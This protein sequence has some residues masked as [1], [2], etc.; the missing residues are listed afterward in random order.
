MSSFALYRL[1]RGVF[2]HFLKFLDRHFCIFSSFFNR[3]TAFSHLLDQH[4]HLTNPNAFFSAFGLD[5]L[6]KIAHNKY[7]SFQFFAHCNAKLF[8]ENFLF[9]RSCF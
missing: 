6:T 8:F 1:Q 2:H 3:H 4:P 9:L 5:A 7:L